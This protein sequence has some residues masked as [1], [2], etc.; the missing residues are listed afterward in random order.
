[1]GELTICSASVVEGERQLTLLSS[2][3]WTQ[4]HI[5]VCFV[6]REEGADVREVCADVR[7]AG[8]GESSSSRDW[9]VE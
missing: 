5:P 3:E 6:V 9:N 8:R 2:W 4:V 7:M 1:M